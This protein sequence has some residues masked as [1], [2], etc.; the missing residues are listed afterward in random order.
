[1]IFEKSVRI[2]SYRL[3]MLDFFLLAPNGRDPYDP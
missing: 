2:V 3:W 1:M